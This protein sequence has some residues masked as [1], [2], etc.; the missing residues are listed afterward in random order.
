MI[1]RWS[2]HRPFLE[3]LSFSQQCW[4]H[5]AGLLDLVLKMKRINCIQNNGFFSTQIQSK[6][7]DFER[8]TFVFLPNCLMA[9]RHET[10]ELLS[11]AANVLVFCSCQPKWMR[12]MEDVS[13]YV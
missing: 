1:L 12:S 11:T 7:E 5:D 4:I 10:T 6:W 2:G 13:V 9:I 3:G 8:F